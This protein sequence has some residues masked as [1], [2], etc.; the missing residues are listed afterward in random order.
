MDL[1][2]ALPKAELHVHLEG[3][4]EPEQMMYLAQRNN[5]LDQIPYD[6]VEEVRKAYDFKDLQSFLDL[7]YAGCAVLLEQQDFYDLTWAY[8]ERAHA[9]GVVHVEPFFDPQTHTQRN[10]PF[11][12][13]VKG[14]HAALKDAEAKW[15]MT[16]GIIICFLRHLGPEAALECLEEALLFK[17]MIMGVGLDSTEIGWPNKLFTEA[18]TR[19]KAE[20]FRLVAHAG[21]EGPAENV[22]QALALGVQRVDHGIHSLEDPDLLKQLAERRMPLTLCPLS[23]LKLK[24]YDGELQERMQELFGL[25]N[26]CIT[27]NSDDPAY[28][29]GY[30]SLQLTTEL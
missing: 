20:G 16:S 18:F 15:G 22:H 4:L 19:A 13:A 25:G 23:N 28:F 24:V 14:V 30:M 17:D 9:E 27:V 21:E 26:L 11:G 8:L 2:D 1:V 12:T 5:V 10:V 3:T 7:Y 6:S 29:G